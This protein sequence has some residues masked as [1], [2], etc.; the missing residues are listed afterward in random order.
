MQKKLIILFLFTNFAT[1]QVDMQLPELGDR[2]SGAISEAEVELLSEQF[3]Q[4]VYTQAS[5]IVDPIIQEYSE[6]LL[7]RLSE[8]SLVND[9]KFTV[10]LIDDPSLNAFAAP[11]GIVGINGGLFL[12]ADNE[13]QFASVLCHELA[14]LSQRHFQ[15]NVLRSQDRNLASALILVSSIAVAIATNNP[16]A[17]IAG[18]ALLQQQ[19]L[20]YSRAFEREADRFGFE[21]CVASGYDPKAMGEMFENMVALRRFYGDNIPEFL[22]TH[23]ISS[24][25]VSD[26]FNAAD[27]LG[28][29][30]GVS[31]SINYKIIKGRLEADY[32]ELPINAVRLFKDKLNN[33]KNIENIYGYSRA[34]FLNG[35]FEESLFQINELLNIYPKNLILNTTKVEI[36]RESEKYEEASILVN[37]L[38]EVSP[39]NYPLTVEKAKVLRGLRKTIA[40]EEIL[41]DTLLR[42]N[43]DPSLWFLLS[44]IQKDNLN[45]AGYHQSRAE[46]FILLGQNERALNELQ[47][48][49][50][51]SQDNFQTFEI[52]MTKINNIR[53][54]LN[55]RI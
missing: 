19:S 54:K 35:R 17:F 41:R 2:V 31:D 10:I 9:R 44:E 47:F 50:K 4:Q 37:E 34:L 36:L 38:L 23:P 40:A 45:V 53:E 51:L 16:G 24:T 15:R 11:G 43:S 25:R 30:E 6:L 18:P 8:T 33:K 3:L 39:K 55:K 32:E 1:S 26:A 42:R 5:L 48:A 29:I 13:S 7:Y 27:Q 28:D 21:N 12:N 14:H 52:I 49:L 20:R 46:Y 22:L